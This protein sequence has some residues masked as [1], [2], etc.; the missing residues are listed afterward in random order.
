MNREEAIDKLN[1]LL[2][3]TDPETV[4]T[5][6]RLPRALRDAA[7]LAVKEFGVAPSTTVMAANALRSMLEAVVMQAALDQHYAEYPETRPSL[8]DL[9]VA[10]AELDGHPLASQPRVIR[11]YADEVVAQHPNASPEEVL[12]WADARRYR[13]T[14]QAKEAA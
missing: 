9:A 5:S 2:D 3:S 6:M 10:A 11:R 1:E 13:E 4:N 8:A 7:S 14:R 12:L